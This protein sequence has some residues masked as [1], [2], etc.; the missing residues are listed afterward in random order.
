MGRPK[1]RKDY[2]DRRYRKF[3][4]LRSHAVAKGKGFLFKDFEDFNAFLEENDFDDTK[5]IC[6]KD[7]HKPFS[8]D[9]CFLAPKN[10]CPDHEVID[11]IA[12][13]TGLSKITV[14]NYILAGKDVN[15]AYRKSASYPEECR[16]PDNIALYRKYISIRT[17]SNQ[18]DVPLEWKT[19]TDFIS[20]SRSNG[21]AKGRYLVRK[22]V[23]GG[24]TAENCLWFKY[25]KYNKN[26]ETM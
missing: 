12:E 9:N 10:M 5:R 18:Y 16:L 8:R 21:Y 15:G 25:K 6:R 23:K 19:M 17:R 1:T 11:E 3:T 14:Y 26:K 4:E 22:N 24:Y 20:W 7:K 13:K 2:G